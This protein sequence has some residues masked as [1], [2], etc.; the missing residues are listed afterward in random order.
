ML[1]SDP[2]LPPTDS[3]RPSG[4]SP[5]LARAF[6]QPLF[7]TLVCFSLWGCGVDPDEA[8]FKLGELGYDYNPGALLLAAIRDDHVAAELLILSG[9]DPNV[10]LAHDALSQLPDPWP[11]NFRREYV[12]SV[13]DHHSDDINTHY[14]NRN[15]EQGG[16]RTTALVV[17]SALGNKDTVEALLAAGA[18]ANKTE[19]HGVTALMWAVDN[20]HAELAELPP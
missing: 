14:L 15:R 16:Y 9:I 7:A 12:E 5:W 18:D 13:F 11:R 10:E 2:R 8:R 6:A 4:S 20:G 1:R 19:C 17:A 3:R